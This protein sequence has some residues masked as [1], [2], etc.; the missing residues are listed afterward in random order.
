MRENYQAVAQPLNDR[1]QPFHLLLGIGPY[2]NSL[3]LIRTAFRQAALRYH[4]DKAGSRGQELYYRARLAFETLNNK[5]SRWVYQMLGPEAV[6][7]PAYQLCRRKL[8]FIS[9]A[10][11]FILLRS[12]AFLLGGVLITRSPRSLTVSLNFL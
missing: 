4:P 3:S 10:M 11:P 6:S 5:R 7:D 8:D 9:T 12:C 2:T 1:T